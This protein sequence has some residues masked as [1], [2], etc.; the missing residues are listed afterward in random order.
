[1]L[2]SGPG[3]KNEKRRRGRAKENPVTK[4]HVIEQ[5]A[6]MPGQGQ[7]NGPDS[8]K[9]DGGGWRAVFGMEMCQAGEE[10]S[11]LAMAR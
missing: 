8:L 1:M 4:D 3:S 11:V 6:V 2:A 7:E 9:Y 10:E 5:V